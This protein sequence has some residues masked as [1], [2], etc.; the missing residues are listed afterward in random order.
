[1]QRLIK[2]EI[3]FE[4]KASEA[5]QRIDTFLVGKLIHR[6]SRTSLKKLIQDGFVLVNNQ[7][8]KAH[9]QIKAD[10]LIILKLPQ[11]AKSGLEAED[12]PLDIVYEDDDLL[13]VNKPS[14]LVTHPA[15]G[16]LTG[17]LVNALLHHCRELSSINMLRPGIVHRL[18]KDTSGLMVV[19]K[20]NSV[21]LELT[22][23]FADHSV[24]RRY[25][26]LVLG[27]VAHDEGFIDL[28]IGRDRRNRKQMAVRF[29]AARPSQTRYKVL[30]RFSDFSLVELA[31]ATGRTHQL[32]VHLKFIG[33]PILG[34]KK[35]GRNSK[36]VIHRLAL[37]AKTLGFFHPSKK[38]FLEFDS[39]LPDEFNQVMQ[40]YAKMKQK[41]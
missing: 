3:S 15:L 26:A 2:E 6:F 8:P 41:T 27:T 20:K 32:R 35:Y 5:S 11:P 33:H 1:M 39:Q 14:G 37:H 36:I 7:K 29:F 9:Y 21:H 13:V 4:V 16:N 31:P 19:A 34:D 40:M 17:T 38:K 23:Q 24:K 22:K 10:D 12:I 25:I 28:P 18:D 30:E